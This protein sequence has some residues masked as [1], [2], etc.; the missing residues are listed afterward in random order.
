MVVAVDVAVLPTWHRIFVGVFCTTEQME[1]RGGIEFVLLVLQLT[2]DTRTGCGV[3][4]NGGA[5]T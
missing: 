4:V 2:V 3:N 5:V 1:V